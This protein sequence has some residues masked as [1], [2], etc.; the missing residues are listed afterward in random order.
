MQKGRALAFPDMVVEE[1]LAP[2]IRQ[3]GFTTPKCA[4]LLVHDLLVII[5]LV[6]PHAGTSLLDAARIVV[7]LQ[8]LVRILPVDGQP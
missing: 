1:L 7:P 3:P 8:P 6:A 5:Q 4:H 2:E